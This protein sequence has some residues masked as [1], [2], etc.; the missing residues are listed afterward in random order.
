M[1]TEHVLSKPYFSMLLIAFFLGLYS[2]SQASVNAISSHD[3]IVSI[4][5]IEQALNIIDNIAGGTSDYALSSPTLMLRIMIQ[6]TEWVDSNRSIVIGI[7][8]NDKQTDI[9]ALIPYKQ[10]NTT[11]QQAYNA[12]HEQGCYMVTL[13]LRQDNHISS[14]VQKELIAASKKKKDHAISLDVN[15]NKIIK[16][17][18]EQIN[19]ISNN[20]NVPENKTSPM[21]FNITP[22]DIKELLLNITGLAGDLENLTM[23]IDLS[24]KELST[25]IEMNAQP[26]TELFKL[27]SQETSMSYLD[28]YSPNQQMNFQSK[29]FDTAGVTKLFND[30]F[31]NF[32]KKMGIDFD[33]ISHIY[34]KFTGEMAGGISFDQNKVYL[35]MIGILKTPQTS[36]NFLETS[37]IPLLT[38]YF[39]TFGKNTGIKGPAKMEQYFIRTSESTVFGHNVVGLKMNMPLY[40]SSAMMHEPSGASQ[41]MEYDLRIT[42]ID[43]LVLTASN[44]KRLGELIQMTKKF[45]QKKTS[46]PLMIM[47]IDLK[48]YLNAIKNMVPMV[49][50][51]GHTISHLGKITCSAD[52]KNGRAVSK[53]SISTQDIKQMIAAFK[54]PE[55]HSHRFIHAS[56]NVPMLEDGT[57]F[58][59]NDVLNNTTL[60]AQSEQG[61]YVVTKESAYWWSKGS[62]CATYGNDK[63]AIRYF[64]KAVE[65]DPKNSGAY[66][67]MG[68][69][70]GELSEFEKAIFHI[71]KAIELMPDNGL[72]YYGKGR[73]YLLEGDINNAMKEITTAARMGNTDAT[74]YLSKRSPISI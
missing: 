50:G 20:M 19:L 38:D 43:N 73:V 11:F 27:F 40:P 46:G 53:F 18:K 67:Q 6:G 9:V 35:E 13:P 47:D 8:F 26:Q 36:S 66:F 61:E 28:G 64:K 54:T 16:K 60:A 70:Y 44:D 65:L 23:D 49:A 30:N 21:H 1:K 10:P 62:I 69:S 41:V 63:G 58:R 59:V 32:Y 74:N 17:S 55:P 25:F 51:K 31:G 39:N 14:I 68:I 4:P 2:T 3:I 29:R 33:K 56:Q 48:S 5:N 22:Q 57:G 7:N 72:Y 45:K 71:N 15:I 34:S 37:Y 42:T 52:M 12:I 24:E